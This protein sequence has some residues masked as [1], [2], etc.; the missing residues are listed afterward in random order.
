MQL[1]TE[2]PED[3]PFFQ[4]E[5]EGLSEHYDLLDSSSNGEAKSAA[6]NLESVVHMIAGRPTRLS[7]FDETGSSISTI[8]YRLNNYSGNTG[9]MPG[10]A[11]L[12]EMTTIQMLQKRYAF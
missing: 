11:G 10:W 12:R 4:A 1:G 7:S 6:L 9:T 5:F 2:D 8:F 3:S